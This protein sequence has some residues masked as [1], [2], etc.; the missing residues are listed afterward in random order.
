MSYD[1]IEFDQLR[2]QQDEVEEDIL[3]YRS[4]ETNKENSIIEDSGEPYIDSCSSPSDID[5]DA[6]EDYKEKLRGKLDDDILTPSMSRI[7]SGGATIILSSECHQTE[8]S[9]I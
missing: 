8:F 6:L 7:L 9:P 2:E 3:K 4:G 1:E 5:S